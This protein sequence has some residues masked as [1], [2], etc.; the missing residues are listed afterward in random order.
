MRNDIRFYVAIELAKVRIN[1]VT[2]Y[3][4]YVTTKLARIRKS[5][6]SIEDFQV[7]IELGEHDRHACASGIR[8]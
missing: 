8:T 5:G 3:H 4:F 1:Y 6:V 2:T 7:A